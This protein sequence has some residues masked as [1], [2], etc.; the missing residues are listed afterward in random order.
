MSL[1]PNDLAR[2]FD[3]TLLK[4]SDT[5]SQISLLCEEAV[6]YQFTSVCIMP[7]W[8]KLANNLLGSVPPAT[9]PSIT[10]VVGFPLG[11]HR[12]EAKARE[13]DDA[14]G[15]GA[16]EIDMVMNVG[17]FLSG[18]HA[19]ISDEIEA[20]QREFGGEERASGLKVIIETSLLSMEQRLQAA[21]LAADAGAGFVKTST[22]FSGGGATVEDVAALRKH[23]PPEVL[24]KASGGIRSAAQALELIEAGAARLGASGS[25]KIVDEV[26]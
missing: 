26:S 11:G 6:A 2:Y 20:V 7:C 18:Y 17:F 13:A 1:A 9:R 16:D 24:I 21:T 5:E 10:T 8:V 3:H 15:E 12:A 23:L 25:T 4:P 22:G 19:L 14:I